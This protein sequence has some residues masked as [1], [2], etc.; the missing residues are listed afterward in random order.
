MAIL[1]KTALSDVQKTAWK[2]VRR[3][4]VDV[5]TVSLVSTQIPAADRVP[6]NVLS[7]PEIQ[8]L[9]VRVVSAGITAVPVNLA[10]LSVLIVTHLLGNVTPVR[11]G[12]GEVHVMIFARPL[13]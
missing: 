9:T 5:T 8:P 13:A 7:A 2:A 4:M 10:P 11:P 12:A 6:V 3:E 1:E